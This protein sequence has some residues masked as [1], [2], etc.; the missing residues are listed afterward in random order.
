[1]NKDLSVSES[2][3]I[4][5]DAP[6]VW[7]VLTNP[8]KI[9]LYMFGTETI[10]DWQVGHE[11]VF[12]GEYQGQQYRDKGT[13]LEFD[14]NNRISYSYWSGFSGLEDT[15][16]NYSKVTYLLDKQGNNVQ[17]TVEQRGFASEQAQQHA[18]GSWAHVLGQI[19]ELA[20]G[21]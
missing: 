19:K 4:A 7:E 14:E 17:L 13:I 8:E 15:P 5:S 11:I 3:E 10:T 2:I 20:E 9:K 21:S 12:Q 6:G 1:M 18:Q 16:E